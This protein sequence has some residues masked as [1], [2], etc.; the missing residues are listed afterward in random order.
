MGGSCSIDA[1]VRNSKGE[2][3]QSRLF[4]DLQAHLNNRGLAKEFYGVGTNPEFLDAVRDKAKFDENGEITFNSLRKLAKI[5]VEE[6][7]LLATLNKEVGAGVHE[8]NDAIARITN[9]NRS[10][11]FKDDYIATITPK[12]GNYEVSVIPRTSSEESKLEKV[13]QDRSLRDRIMYRL[14]QAGVSVQF[15][16]EDS[17]VHGRYSTE[18]VERTA[19]G[20]YQLIRLSRGEKLTVTLAEEAGHFAIGSLGNSP[21]VERL[22]NL[23]ANEDTRKAIYGEDYTSTVGSESPREVAGHLVGKAIMDEVDKDTVWGKLSHRIVD[24]AKKIYATIKSDS[25]MMAKLEAKNIA[26]SIARGFMT[27]KQQGNIEEALKIKETLYNAEYSTNAK[28]YKQVIN[29]LDVAVSKLKAICGDSLWQKTKLILRAAESGRHTYINTNPDDI[30]ANNMALDGMAEVVSNILDMIG[31]GKELV[32]MLES[33]NFADTTEFYSNMAENG[34]KLRQVRTFVK[35]AA[36]MNNIIIQ[37]SRTLAGKDAVSGQLDAIQITDSF[38]N[39]ETI[40]LKNITSLLTKA[41]QDVTNDLMV[42]EKQFFLKFCEDILGSKYVSYASKMIWN[43]GKNRKENP[44]GKTRILRVEEAKEVS[45]SQLLET[46]DYDISFFDKWVSSMSNNADVI[47]QIYDRAVKAANKTADDL[48]NKCWDDL[49]ILEE[50]FKEF[51]IKKEDLFERDEEGNFTGNIISEFKWGEYE[52]KFKEY[53]DEKIKEFKESTPNLKSMSETERAIALE[54]FLRPFIKQWHKENSTYNKSLGRYV[55]SSGSE[56]GSDVVKV[57]YRNYDFD[58]LMAS[59]PGLRQWYN[60]FMAIK[61]ELDHLLPEGCTNNVRLPQFKGTF[62][63]IARNNGGIILGSGR[64]VASKIYDTFCES[65]EDTM[66]GGDHIYNSEEEE[67]FYNHLAHEKEKINR[68]P[69]FGINKLK[70][71]NDLSTDI[72]G[73][74]LAYAGMAYTYASMDNV[75]HTLEV[76]REVLLR[77]HVAGTESET[78]RSGD[79]SNCFCRVGK[80]MDKQVYGISSSKFKIGE[81]VVFEKVVSA[82]TSFSSKYFLGGNLAGGMVNTMTGFNELFKEAFSGEHFNVYDFTKANFQ[83]WA[84]LPANFG[85]GS[86]FKSDKL[87]LFIRHFNVLGTNKEKYRQW[88]TNSGRRALNIIKNAW[89]LP[90][91]TGE[92]Y[93]QSIS[94]LIMAN[95]IKVYDKDGK[96]YKL[97]DAYQAD[98]NTY[99]RYDL[100]KMRA[101]GDDVSDIEDEKSLKGKGKTLKLRDVMFKNKEDITTYNTI[102]SIIEQLE[103]V[104]E[105]VFGIN[106]LN[107]SDEELD[108]LNSKGYNIDTTDEDVKGHRKNIIRHLQEDASNLTWTQ[109]DETIFMD[110][111]R[112]INNRMHG[113]YNNQDKTAFHQMWYGNAA[114]S[115]KGW[116]L[117]MME[118]R[119]SRNHHS[120]SLDHDVEGSMMTFGKLIAS[121]PTLGFGNMLWA[122]VAPTSKRNMKKLQEAGFSKNQVHNLKRN[123]GDFILIGLFYL[124]HHLTRFIPEDYEWEDEEWD[125]EKGDQLLGILHYFSNRLYKEQAAF[126]LPKRAYF[127]A[128]TLG[129]IVPS[130]ASALFDLL[131]L[132]KKFFGSFIADESNTEYFYDQTKPGLYEQYDPKW[133]THVRG[134]TPYWR[135]FGVFTHPYYSTKSYDYGTNIKAR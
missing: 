36:E 2:V 135:S 71:M 15:I 25:V 22:T 129:D 132:N 101:E 81:H 41:L 86:E 103:A 109:A 38:G 90:Y 49:R 10:S 99:T 52:K 5:D 27:E 54:K 61:R 95:K 84:N 66:F 42:K 134:K 133:Y 112:E 123:L 120:L 108:Y 87:S 85:P 53:K 124:I 50:R 111:C 60:Q 128:S 30:Q 88:N 63:N 78:T 75:V 119:W 51:G 118:R 45:I 19:E 7:K 89:F 46:L 93:M 12:E 92:H 65:S 8:Y 104:N 16:E 73:S 31:P 9:F 130:G 91:K 83:Y 33:V 94:Y 121:T 6:E 34:R 26:R 69:L 4:N 125:G 59:K 48:T 127:E 105:D 76:G 113:I 55:P 28:T 117:G 98:D 126:H 18:N 1:H 80:F 106:T 24:L 3:V 97:Y 110:K 21:L 11:G 14:N 70:D 74:M 43:L 47:G 79:R 37:A 131:T 100:E 17:K 58:A 102:N 68:L 23:V 82:L 72:F 40:D 20:M 29:Q 64:A 32:N 114:L 67:L 44:E 39:I 107:L 122:I 62:I 13:I 115:M 56:E 116:A 96:E 77:R 57:D 35:H